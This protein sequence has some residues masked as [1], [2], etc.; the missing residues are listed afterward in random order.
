MG[1]PVG[2][3]ALAVTVVMMVFAALGWVGF[4]GR[5]GEVVR[6]QGIR[7]TPTRAFSKNPTAHG[8]AGQ[9]QGCQEQ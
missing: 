7:Q 4:V 6:N 9:R 2:N 8:H 5:I 3:L 1:W